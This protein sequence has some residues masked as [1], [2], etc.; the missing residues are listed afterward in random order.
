MLARFCVAVR[1]APCA[2]HQLI[3][4]TNINVAGAQSCA[5]IQRAFSTASVAQT[6][7]ECEFIHKEYSDPTH[8]NSNK[9]ALKID[10]RTLGLSERA[11]QRLIDIVGPRYSKNTRV[12]KL[13]SNSFPT[14]GQNKKNLKVQLK[15]IVDES[16]KA[17]QLTAEQYATYK[18][19]DPFYKPPVPALQKR[20]EKYANDLWDEEIVNEDDVDLESVLQM[21]GGEPAPEGD[22]TKRAQQ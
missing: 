7:I 11:H 9:V 12:L 10:I 19:Q 6:E 3:R 16:R 8:P 20:L 15:G 21:D 13:T 5:Y 17:D 1:S 22:S 18:I 14:V 4:P 2:Q